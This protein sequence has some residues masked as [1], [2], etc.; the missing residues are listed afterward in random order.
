MGAKISNK[1]NG[2]GSTRNSVRKTSAHEQAIQSILGSSE[3]RD[4]RGME[5]AET[6][7]AA[8]PPMRK[9]SVGLIGMDTE[10]ALKD[11]FSYH[12]EKDVSAMDSGFISW[13][14]TPKR[15]SKRVRRSTDHD[16]NSALLK[17]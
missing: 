13:P 4:L 2:M 5:S 3:F 10:P 11:L 12:L 8:K 16:G 14:C 17:E 15:Q 1:S 9:I 7:R 6:N